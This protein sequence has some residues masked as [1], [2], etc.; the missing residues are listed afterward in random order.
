MEYLQYR[1]PVVQ[2]DDGGTDSKNLEG[3][4]TASNG[5]GIQHHVSHLTKTG[6]LV[7]T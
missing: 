7:E 2:D 6:E 4:S 3:R 5:K 1:S